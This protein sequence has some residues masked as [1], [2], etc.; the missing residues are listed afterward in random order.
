MRA[1]AIAIV[2]TSIIGCMDKGSQLD[3]KDS[4]A[5]IKYDM[6]DADMRYVIYTHRR[7]GVDIINVTLDSLKVYEIKK[8]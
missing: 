7:G 5:L 8:K 2:L 3:V 6:I 1:I 4:R